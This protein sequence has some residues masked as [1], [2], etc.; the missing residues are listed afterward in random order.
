MMPKLYSGDTGTVSYM[1]EIVVHC[2]DMLSSSYQQFA[3]DN[4]GRDKEGSWIIQEKFVAFQRM[5]EAIDVERNT[6]IVSTL[7]RSPWP[8][9]LNCTCADDAP[10]FEMTVLAAP[11]GQALEPRLHPAGTILLYKLLYGNGRMR[12]FIKSREI[13][14]EDLDET[15]LIRLAGLSRVFESTAGEPAA[16]LEVA[17]YPPRR[18][19]EG[20]GSFSGFTLDSLSKMCQLSFDQ[21]EIKS[22]FSK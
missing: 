4:V 9:W 18:V 11:A 1:D 13:K 22:C 15:L 17:L 10:S 14:K 21:E 19:D 20:F 16:V 12:S 2:R 7:Q 3:M 6:A 5:I 8:L